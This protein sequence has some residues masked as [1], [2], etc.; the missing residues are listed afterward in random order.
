[1]NN[2]T[3]GG[4]EFFSDKIGPKIIAL[5]PGFEESVQGAGVKANLPL[6][7]DR[8]SLVCRVVQVYT[9]QKLLYKMQLRCCPRSEPWHQR[10]LQ[11]NAEHLCDS[12]VLLIAVAVECWAQVLQ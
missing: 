9:S 2:C 10:V 11:T 5:P 7:E 1:M 8:E 4:A 3:R 6:A 12:A